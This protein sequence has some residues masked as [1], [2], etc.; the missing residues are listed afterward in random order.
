MTRKSARI[1]TRAL[2]AVLALTGAGGAAGAPSAA[3]VRGAAPSTLR[4]SATLDGRDLT[5][6]TAGRPLRLRPDHPAELGLDVTNTGGS[7]AVVRNVRLEGRVM[8]LVFFSFSTRID[9]TVHGGEHVN[10]VIDLDLSDLD[11][12]AVGLI[13]TEVT[14]LS[15]TRKS[16]GSQALVVDVR[17]SITSTYGV[18]GVS[19]AVLTLLFGAAVG[20]ALARHRLPVNR[21]SR[22]LR[23]LP[24][25]IG[26]GLTVT[27]TLSATRLLT[28]APAIWAPTVAGC[29]VAAFLLGYFTPTPDPLPA[30]PG[31]RSG[32]AES[33]TDPRATA[34]GA[35]QIGSDQIGPGQVGAGQIGSDRIGPGQVGA[36]QIRPAGGLPWL[37]GTPPGPVE[38]RRDE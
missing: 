27:F 8:G 19:V 34:V 17:G 31:L 35:G 3:A 24:V 22:A 16:L 23:F 6:A 12:Q 7:D 11:G 2:L 5:S 1:L 20:L 21:W 30:G 25:G 9:L 29:A 4:W 26:L 15:P 10:R 32:P 14:L 13:P 37:P 18:F 28:P 33:P 38:L 36:E